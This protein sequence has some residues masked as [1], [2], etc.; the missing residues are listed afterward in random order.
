MIKA[1]L[2]PAPPTRHEYWQ[3]RALPSE[4]RKGQSLY[5]DELIKVFETHLPRGESRTALEIG[6][7]PGGYLAFMHRGLGYDITVLDYSE[8]GCRMAKKNFEPLAFLRLCLVGMCSKPADRLPRF[9]LVF[10]LGLIEHFSEPEHVIQAHLRYLKPGGTL[11]IGCPNFLGVNRAIVKRLAPSLLHSLDPG[12]TS[13]KRWSTFDST[14]GLSRAFLGYVGGFEPLVA[15]AAKVV[16][17]EPARSFGW[18][19]WPR[20]CTTQRAVPFAAS[21][22]AGGV[23]ISSASIGLRRRCPRDELDSDKV[24]LVGHSTVYA[25]PVFEQLVVV[26][27]ELILESCPSGWWSLASPRA[28]VQAILSQ[29]LPNVSVG[30]NMLEDRGGEDRVRRRVPLG[31]ANQ[32]VDDRLDLRVAALARSD[33]RRRDVEA[34]DLQVERL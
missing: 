25:P 1:K 20:S 33:K 9:D 14:F 5:L 10:S 18:P 19:S 3:Q 23:A 17:L 31:S 6:G 29:P 34:A 11:M 26:V 13:I 32:V 22:R 15:G 27:R 28:G 12:V 16:A 24:V 8:L 2:S 30:R 21:T 4:I 7:A